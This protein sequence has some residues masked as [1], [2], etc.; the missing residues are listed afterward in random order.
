[1]EN[2]PNLQAIQDLWGFLKL[3]VVLLV[4]FL[5]REFAPKLWDYW[6]HRKKA[7]ADTHLSEA[8]TRREIAQAETMEMQVIH[9]AMELLNQRKTELTGMYGEAKQ[10]IGELEAQY[11][12]LCGERDTWQK[13]AAELI[14]L[15]QLNLLKTTAPVHNGGCV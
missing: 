2:S 10:R 4:G 15:R 6:V 3:P 1:M 12:T 14:E 8:Q 9:E 7:D 13:D 5:V 11:K